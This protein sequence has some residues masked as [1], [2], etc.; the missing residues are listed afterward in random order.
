MVDKLFTFFGHP[1]IKRVLA[2]LLFVG[3]VILL[4]HLAALYVFYL[5]LSRGFGF[6]ATKLSG[7]TRVGEKVWVVAL[8]V[9]LLGA[10]GGGVY[11]GVHRS[12]PTVIRLS[13]SAP[14]RVQ[15]FKDT[16]LYKM[17]EEHVDLDKYEEQIQHFTQSL[18]KALRS[19]GRVLLHLVIALILAVLYLFERREVDALYAGVPARSVLGNVVAFF[20]F[21]A[22]AI[23]LTVKVQVIVA[24][25]NAVIT[26]PIL[27]G[28]GLP[29]VA[30][31]MVMV[32][33]FGLVPVVGNFL[34]GTV[35]VILSYL[36]KGWIGV[37][38]FLVSTFVLH[39]IESYYL[40]PRLTAQHV[41][42][43]SL[44]LIAS[45]IIWE[46]LVG[47]AGIFIS[48]PVLYVG[49]RTRDLFRTQD[50]ADAEQKAQIATTS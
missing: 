40:N 9:L 18:L 3:G 8:V 22:D 33:A 10:I 50:L 36:R 16:D 45:L 2:L 38:V 29:H 49:L 25:V 41:K 7:W 43:P 6:L 17:V 4:R 47:V 34:S 20:T 19:T 42:L 11:A 12:L 30:S 44:F 14:E 1:N 15:A 5:I 32:F 23:L 37:G 46:H 13:H 48:F 21:A 26:L 27:I 39:K 31:L 24:A 28:L 35:L